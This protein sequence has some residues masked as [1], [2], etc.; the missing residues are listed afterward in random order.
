MVTFHLYFNKI[1][2]F[3]YKLSGFKCADQ[4]GCP[5]SNLNYVTHWEV[6]YLSVP[7][8]LHLKNGGLILL[9]SQGFYFSGLNMVYL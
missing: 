5:I 3:P 1:I 2:L 9:T 6:T 4:P 7:Q 8:L